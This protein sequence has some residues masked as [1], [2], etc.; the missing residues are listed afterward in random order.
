[1]DAS[2]VRYV[3]RAVGL[4]AVLALTSCGSDELVSNSTGILATGSVLAIAP[5]ILLFVVL[6]RYI[7]GAFVAGA[8]KG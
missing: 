1:M 7:V 5:A 6:Q 2:R 4:L 3:G 8:L